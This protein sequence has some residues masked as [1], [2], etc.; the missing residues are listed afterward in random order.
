VLGADEL[1]A[2]LRAPASLQG[3][4]DRRAALVRRADGGRH[5]ALGEAQALV[6]DHALG[7][8][9]EAVAH[10]ALARPHRQRAQEPAAGAA[11][12]DA[13]RRERDLDAQG[14]LLDDVLRGGGRGHGGSF[15]PLVASAR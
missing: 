4:R 9:H 12:V 3:E 6:G 15:S 2:Q 8:L 11:D 7:D 1:D 10:L 5:R 14:S 13:E